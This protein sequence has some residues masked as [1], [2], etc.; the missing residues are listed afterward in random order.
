MAPQKASV[1]FNMGS[2]QVWEGT[3][4]HDQVLLKQCRASRQM[5]DK[6]LIDG[7]QFGV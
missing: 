3:I 4:D 5:L 1:P 6:Y 7:M 2:M